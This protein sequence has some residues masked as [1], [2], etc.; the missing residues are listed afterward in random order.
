MFHFQYL[1]HQIYH[2]EVFHPCLL[3]CIFE[4]KMF[5]E[6]KVLSRGPIEPSNCNK[7]LIV[8][9]EGVVGGELELPRSLSCKV[10][11]V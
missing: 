5:L 7:T 11:I 2:L 4:G 1:S 3:N 10:H 9:K 6:V 8:I